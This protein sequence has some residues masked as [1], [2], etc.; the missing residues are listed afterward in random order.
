MMSLLFKILFNAFIIITLSNISYPQNQLPDP[1]QEKI[2]LKGLEET[3]DFNFDKSRKIFNNLILSN[4]EDP[5]GYHFKS[6]EFL[7]KFLDNK[8]DSDL[9]KFLGLSDTVIRNANSLPD[10]IS[11]TAYINYIIGSTY[12]YRAMVYTRLENYMDVI[13]ATQEALSYLSAAIFID[14][15][16]YDAYMGLGLFNFMIAQTPPALK[17]AMRL[18]GVK[19][20]KVKGIEY[21]KLAAKNG[22]FSRI[23]AQFFLSQILSE[24]YQENEEAEKLMYDLNIMYKNN[25]LFQHSF[26]VFYLRMANLNRAERIFNKLISSTDSSFVQLIRY[27]NLSLGDVFFFRNEF[28]SAKYYYTIF[29]QDLNENYY[30]GIAALRL[31]LCFSFTGDSISAAENFNLANKG[32]IDIDDDRYASVMAEEYLENPPDTTELKIIFIDNLINA[33]NYEEAKDSLLSL[34]NM[35]FTNDLLAEINLQ[36]SNVSFYLDSLI[37]SYSYALS[38]IAN[39]DAKPMVKVFAFY[40]AARVSLKLGYPADAEMYLKKIENY[41]DYFYENKLANLINALEYKLVKYKN[42]QQ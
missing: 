29:P 21:L 14:S 26:A 30:R 19:G 8:S 35:D 6:I 9:V 22:K 27:S 5:A 23:E 32:N 2:I 13:L 18:T 12:S 28:D 15:T 7:W 1:H 24:F 41:S 33:G 10:S 3:F 17:W 36:L 34:R 20:D 25:M 31:G 38:A 42:F 16:F 39:D 40:Y 4:P 37:D 11:G